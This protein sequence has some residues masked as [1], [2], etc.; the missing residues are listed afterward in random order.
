MQTKVER[1]SSIEGW[2]RRRPQVPADLESPAR[3]VWD[4]EDLNANFRPRLVT[5]GV[6]RFGLSEDDCEAAAQH[7][8]LKALAMNPRVRDPKAFLRAAF[9][10]QCYRL[11][12]RREGP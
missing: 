2:D 7:V 8:F 9:L 12:G 3:P 4:W 5:A 6:I 1:I 10:E 11:L